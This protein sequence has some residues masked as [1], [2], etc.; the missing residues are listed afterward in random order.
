MSFS[1]RWWGKLQL[2]SEPDLEL[3]HRS[4]LELLQATGV[5][6]SNDYARRFFEEAGFQVEGNIVKFK[7]HQIEDAIR[8]APSSFVR[9]GL[10]AKYDMEV[11]GGQ[12]YLGAG[13]VSLYVVEPDTF[14]RRLATWQDL[15]RFT[16]LADGLEN[17]QVGNGLVKPHDMPESILHVVWSWNLVNNS[18]KAANAY[19]AITMQEAQDVIGVLSAVCG[20]EQALRESHRWTIT[21]CPDQALSWGNIMVGLVEMCKV[22]QP[23][24]IMSMPLM[25]SMHPVTIGGAL[26]QANAE[27]LSA[28]ALVQLV[29]PGAPTIYNYYGGTLDMR[30]G[31]VAFGA[32]EGALCHAAAVQLAKWY[33]LPCDVGVGHTDSKVPDAQAAYE[34][35]MSMLP[36]ALA[37]ADNMRLIGGE[38]DFGLTSSY[39]ELVIDNEI[40]G[41]VLRMRKG[42]T[43]SDETLALDAIKETGPGG[44]YLIHPHTLR[45][46][47][48]EVWR[49]TLADRQ[50]RDSWEAAGSK[51]ILVRAHERAEEILANHRV[52]PLTPARRE[53]VS[54]IVREVCE[55]EGCAEWWDEVGSQCGV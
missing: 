21:C 1:S 35:M 5:R 22:E 52:Q 32:P 42:F 26:V 24:V 45:H 2:L 11:G 18:L 30:T 16:R 28:L 10:D 51:P 4:T 20:S 19:P 14:T 23:I 46:F 15:Q 40:A 13:S 27:V 50:S 34:K 49:P 43:V 12:L 17:L 7:P 33:G 47:R 55:R 3:I 39:E 36:A 25:G 48:Q 9:R 53:E 6:F 54:A 44:N 31:A 29:N 38:L 41:Q 8:K 37:G